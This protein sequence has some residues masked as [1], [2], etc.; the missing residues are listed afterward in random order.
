MA[1]RGHRAL[2]AGGCVRDLLLGRA[3]KDYDVATSALPDQVEA[4]FDRT[5]AVGKAF[6]VVRVGAPAGDAFVEVATFRSDGP[7]R[8]GR[9]PSHV[10]F[11]GEQADAARRDFTINA[12]FLDPA[13]GEVLDY[14]G[15]RADLEARLIRAVGDPT[16]RFDEDKLRL[17]RA[18]RFEANLG[19][20]LEPA[21][22]AALTA[23][24]PQIG[25]CSAERIRDELEKLITNRGASR[26]LQR[27]LETGLLAAILP[28]LAAMPG[29]PQ[30]PEFH[31]EGDV[32]VHTLLAMDKINY[33]CTVTLALGVLLHDV[34]KP[35]TCDASGDRIRFHGHDKLG[36][37]MAGEILRR[38]RF[39]AEVIERVQSLVADHLKFMHARRMKTST[40]KRW[41]RKPHFDEDLE[42]HRIDCLAG[43]QTLE[44]WQFV[45]DKLAEFAAAPAALRPKL[46]I[47]GHDL[48]AI[49]L[50]PG[51]LYRRILTALEDEMLEGRALDRQQALA[52]AR[53]IAA[54]EPGPDPA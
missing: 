43:P 32:W 21:T 8:D 37:Q 33:P 46:P 31:P 30:P 5:V 7:Y 27:M 35:P 29:V 49:G 26:G 39:P 34:G 11:G 16:R 19:F 12:L 52:R 25:V 47:D 18:V 51:P 44:T 42:L 20:S 2:L 23:L 48:R 40:L 17:L 22:L 41:L 4:L 50:A 3:P 1:A 13:S 6:G 28:E 14:T 9:H 38:L 54:G 45:R 10:S 15:G 36:A 24:A 53:E